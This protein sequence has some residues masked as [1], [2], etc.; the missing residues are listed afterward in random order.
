MATGGG[1]GRGGG[2]GGEVR[3]AAGHDTGAVALRRF[4]LCIDFVD[5]RHDDRTAPACTARDLRKGVEGG[6]GAAETFQQLSEGDGANILRAGEADPVAPLIV[7]QDWH[8]TH[9]SGF[10][11]GVP[12]RGSVPLKR[13]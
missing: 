4:D 13:R 7:G 8:Q 9:A 12:K 10:A 11:F 1:G 3:L 2:G 5:R 6:G